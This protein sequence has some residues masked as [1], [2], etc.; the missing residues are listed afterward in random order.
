[1]VLV[2]TILAPLALNRILRSPQRSGGSAEG[3]EPDSIRRAMDN[4]AIGGDEKERRP[5]DLG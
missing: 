2:T 4:P 3:D 5:D 1:M